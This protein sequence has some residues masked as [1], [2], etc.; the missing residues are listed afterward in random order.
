MGDLEG[1][2]RRTLT[3]Y[4]FGLCIFYDIIWTRNHVLFFCP[5]FLSVANN[6]PMTNV[7]LLIKEAKVIYSD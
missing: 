7:K 4:A 2:K 3:K 1:V 5:C 6:G